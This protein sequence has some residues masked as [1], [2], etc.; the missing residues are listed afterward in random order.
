MAANHIYNVVGDA[1]PARTAFIVA[2]DEQLYREKQHTPFCLWHALNAIVARPG[3]LVSL[4]L[5]RCVYHLASVN[6]VIYHTLHVENW[7]KRQL[8]KIANPERRVPDDVQVVDED[9]VIVGEDPFPTR[10]IHPNGFD[11]VGLR[12]LLGDHGVSC[13]G[14]FD[15]II[16]K[17]PLISLQDDHGDC[18]NWLNFSSPVPVAGLILHKGWHFTALR[19]VCNLNGSREWHH[20]DSMY[21]NVA[22]GSHG[23]SHVLTRDEFNAL[24]LDEL[25]SVVIIPTF[26]ADV[27]FNSL[28]SVY[29]ND[30]DIL[31]SYRR[32]GAQRVGPVAS[33]T[34]HS[35]SGRSSVK[36]S[37][38]VV[39]ASTVSTVVDLCDDSVRPLHNGLSETVVCF[40]VVLCTI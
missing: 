15:N 8:E 4:A 23:P 24:I 31:D 16:L 38:P 37:A 33:T 14:I 32:A 13:S 22:K 12:S 27:V 11:F 28:S 1:H 29:S 6:R 18:G 39:S 21:P 9:L 25:V 7:R 35:S 5:A 20:I 3:C 30:I 2:P 40:M 17:R 34:A 10:L 26:D 19:L 36:V